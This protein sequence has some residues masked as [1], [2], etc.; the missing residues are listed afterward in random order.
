M[1]SLGQQHWP[2][3]FVAV[4]HQNDLCPARGIVGW[5]GE[6][7]IVRPH[8]GNGQPRT[9]EDKIHLHIGGMNCL[10]V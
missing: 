9:V 7:D 4:Y 3:F 1:N 5:L 10:L 8:V 6:A 2:A